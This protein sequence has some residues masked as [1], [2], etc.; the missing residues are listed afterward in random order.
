[1]QAFDRVVRR[2]R[3]GHAYLFAGPGGIGKR[4]FAE[5]LAR[6]LLC[7]SPV[8][9]RLE[10]CDLCPA[11]RQVAAGTHPDLFIAGK[12]EESLELP[13]DVMRDLC[14]SFSLKS[15]R[16]RGKVVILDDADDLN[17]ESANCF[18][19]TLEEP[20]PRSVLLLVGTSPDR[21]LATIRSRC[22]V[23][24]F[25][26]LADELVAELLRAQGVEDPALIERLVRLSGGSPGRARALADPALWEFRRQML[27][28]LSRSPV[29]TVG[30]ARSWMRFVEEA[31][32]EAAAQRQRAAQVLELLI[33][34]L[35]AALSRSVGT[36]PRL[37]EPED[38]RALE[39]L[40]K[41]TDAD[42]L[43]SVLDRCL[44]AGMHIDRRVQL[45]LIVEALVDALGQ[46][47]RSA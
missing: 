44:E 28:Q 46:R 20:P 30:L 9:T 1:V 17:E 8:R 4:L 16:D 42:R 33:D 21:Q 13:I 12:P 40:V 14:R 47:L 26:P 22:Q 15:A 24:H 32:K 7:E 36:R 23:V 5:E 18:L 25:A 34:F 19:K 31:G 3:L 45:V 11:C 39:E 43:G 37:A 10:A 29:D 6:A 27:G 38:L 2:G 41:H 35:S